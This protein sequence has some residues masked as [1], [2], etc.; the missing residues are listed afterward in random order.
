MEKQDTGLNYL[1][2]SIKIFENNKDP[3]STSDACRII[4]TCF[5]EKNKAPT[6]TG[7]SFPKETY[8]IK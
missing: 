8:R 6:L 4:A 2:E 1:R 7:S 5:K 3:Y